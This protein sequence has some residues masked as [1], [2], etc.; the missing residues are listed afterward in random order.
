MNKTT[1]LRRS[2]LVLGLLG[3]GLLLACDSSVAGPELQDPGAAVVVG[4][5][6]A[7]SGGGG[8][9][10]QDLSGIEV[11]V[12]GSSATD[13]TDING[14]F[15]LEARSEDGRLRLRFRKGAIDVGLEISGAGP[16]TVVRIDVSLD[17][18]KATL[19][20]SSSSSRGE[21]E[22]EASLVGLSG[23][24]PSRTLR[25]QVTR[26]GSSTLVEVVE[27]STVFDAEGDLI[28]FDRLSARVEAGLQVRVEGDGSLQAD[29]TV[30]ATIIKAETDEE[31]D[32][33]LGDDDEDFEGRLTALSLSGSA[34]NRV[35]RVALQEDGKQYAVDIDEAATVFQQDGD[36]LTFEQLISGHDAG[37]VIE[38]EGNG[39]RQ[40]DGSFIATSVKVETDD[41]DDDS[42]DR[43]E[44]VLVSLVVSGAAPSRVA[45]AV[46]D[47]D[48][49]KR[50]T[51]LI[52]ESATVFEQD[53][54]LV[55]FEQLLA[56]YD[57]GVALEIE[58]VGT[59]QE[60][61]SVLASI[62]EVEIDD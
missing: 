9:S 44:G 22:G 24:S 60:D 50:H 28:T 11:T 62:I 42:G 6:R 57:G 52:D 29:G 12:E 1:R 8:Q 3:T 45:E 53:G 41:D 18:G 21:F 58:G 39:D 54:D 16:G 7:A 2:S 56:A 27:G 48:G 61:G 19:D 34:P 59:P 15:R 33:D 35:A 32:D 49:Q 30:S 46:L 13:T 55:S 5:V 20:D 43:F 51:V 14:T 47:D 37:A 40:S 38:I 25:L 26:P 31:D 4:Q 23:S 17:S 36:L 10:A